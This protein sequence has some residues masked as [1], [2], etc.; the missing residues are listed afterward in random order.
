MGGL[1]NPPM[2]GDLFGDRGRAW[3]NRSTF[4]D[5]A[6]TAGRTK[7]YAGWEIYYWMLD[8]A[9]LSE[10]EK[11]EGEIRAMGRRRFE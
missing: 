5:P 2:L 3:V 1:W 10:A 4:P 11:L 7:L 8:H 6:W 9:R